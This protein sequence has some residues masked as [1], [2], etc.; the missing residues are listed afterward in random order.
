MGFRASGLGPLG[1]RA[2]G[3]GLR[4]WGL[5]FSAYG[6]GSRAQK[7]GLRAKAVVNGL[8]L[9]VRKTEADSGMAFAGK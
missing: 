8:A 3:V 7:L 6:K 2:Q 4:V 1:F 9:A 5:W